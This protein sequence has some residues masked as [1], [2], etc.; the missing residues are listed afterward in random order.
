MIAGVNNIA[1][2]VYGSGFLANCTTVFM[3]IRLMMLFSLMFSGVAPKLM[4]KAASQRIRGL[5]THAF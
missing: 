5:G 2:P 4:P 3:H 1:P